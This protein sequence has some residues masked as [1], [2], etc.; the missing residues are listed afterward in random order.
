MNDRISQYRS[1][2][3]SIYPPQRAGGNCRW[4]LLESR[5]KRGIPAGVILSDGIIASAPSHPTEAEVVM[6]MDAALAQMR[7]Y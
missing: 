2:R 5:I 1:A 3:L 6:L 4:A 7:L